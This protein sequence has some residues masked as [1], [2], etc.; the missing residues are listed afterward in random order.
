[1]FLCK[2]LNN[3]FDIVALKHY[4]IIVGISVHFDLHLQNLF[5]LTCSW[6]WV[7]K[8]FL[9]LALRRYV[10]SLSWVGPSSRGL[11]KIQLCIWHS[12]ILLLISTSRPLSIKDRF[13]CAVYLLLVEFNIVLLSVRPRLWLV[14][15][16]RNIFILPLRR[17]RLL[18]WTH[19]AS[20]AVR[21]LQRNLELLH[22]SF[23]DNHSRVFLESIR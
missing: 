22:F 17:S 11:S 3:L 6:S 8:L 13:E 15:V 5:S 19:S 20:T 18:P 1:M 23:L 12:I 21:L 2:K 14:Q 9:S 4:Q 7:E 16:L 10:A